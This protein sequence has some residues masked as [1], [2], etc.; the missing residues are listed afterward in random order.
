MHRENPNPE[1]KTEELQLRSLTREKQAERNTAYNSVL[2]T[3][4][5]L[6]LWY[7][8]RHLYLLGTLLCAKQCGVREL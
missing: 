8:R 2:K 5:Y 3:M 4:R 6:A 7:A 1:I